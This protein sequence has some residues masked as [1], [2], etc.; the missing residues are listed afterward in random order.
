MIGDRVDLLAHV[1]GEVC[2]DPQLE[3]PT[4]TPSAARPTDR[5][6]LAAARA[7]TMASS[8]DAHARRS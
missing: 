5:A 8:T 3:P 2:L 6:H 7:P 4:M 1:Y